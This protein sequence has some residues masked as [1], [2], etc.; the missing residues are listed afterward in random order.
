M[1]IDT[2]QIAD[3]STI[4]ADLCIVGGGL[5]GLAFASRFLDRDTRVVLLESGRVG[6]DP[7]AD[8]LSEGSTTAHPSVPL[9]ES[10]PRRLGGAAET[11]GAW[12]RPLEDID[13]ERRE[14]PWSGWPVGA[15][16]MAPYFEQAL[17]Y[18]E[19]SDRGF[20]GEAW[21]DGLPP[22]YRH[23]Q[24]ETALNVGVWQESPLAPISER[25]AGRL[26]A[27]ENLLVHLGA[28]ALEIRT[29][30]DEDR[31]I[32][33]D[34][35]TFNG[36]RFTVHADQ[37]VL[38]GGTLGTVRL[39]LSSR[40]R[41]TLGVG[42]EHGMVGRFFAEHP[43]I[44]A[45][46]F[47]LAKASGR[48]RFPAID[49]GLGGTMARI[50][51]ERPK[52]GIRAGICLD[53]DLRRRENLLNVIAHLRPPSVEPPRVA[54]EFFRELRHRNLK[55]VV[56]G[57]PGLLRHLPEVVSVVYRRL[58]KR[59]RE[60][61]L[62]VQTE[63]LPNPDSRVVLS[64]DKDRFGMPRAELQWRIGA[65]DKELVAR[66]AQLMGEELEAMGLGPFQREPWL[67]DPGEFWSSEPFGG[68]HLMG[69]T[70]MSVAPEEG[71]VDPDGRVHGVSN[72][73]IVGPSVFPTY[74][75]ANPGMTIVATALRTAERVAVDLPGP[76]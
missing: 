36:K 23:I 28:T 1:L 70:R 37:Y 34:A 76:A 55:N 22:L 40:G 59:P 31:V 9:S 11:W 68:L 52:S 33:I 61:E 73:W 45:G 12:C 24:D 48:P 26:D 38:A 14:W 20:T 44:V 8:D 69:T 30:A 5:A 71:V 60:L 64:G 66:T 25:V 56:R 35:G 43:H 29:G 41:S 27:A 3:G 42:N 18:L 7:E 15:E 65:L 32:G 63:T 19:M 72:L 54:L 13:F 49:R 53:E 4:E 58:L 10:A 21:A 57:I 16:E 6:E 51:M 74:G 46:R 75:A 39:L 67:D 50:E 47:S 62:Y 2:T 17:E